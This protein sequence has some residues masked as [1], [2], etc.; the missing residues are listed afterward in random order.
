MKDTLIGALTGAGKS[1]EL[2]VHPDQIEVLILPYGGRVLGLFAAGSSQNFL[3]THPA[4]STVSTARSF[5][6]SDQ[7]HNSGGDRTWLAPE[8]DFFFPEFP[9][10][11]RYWQPRQL[12]PGDYQLTRGDAELMLTNHL[13]ARLSRSKEEVEVRITKVIAPAADPLRHE[14]GISKSG[15][16]Y[17]GYTLRTTL[18][19]T[20]GG[21]G[22]SVV[23]LW[24]LLQLPHGGELLIPTHVRTQPRIYFGTIAPDDLIVGDH[25]VRYRMQATGEQKIGIRAVAATGRLAYRHRTGDGQWVLVIRN[26]FVNPSGAYVDFPWNGP[27]ELG[28]ALQACSIN[29]GLGR[30]S[31]LE[32]HVPAIGPATG[33]LIMEDASQVWAYRGTREQID[34]VT[35]ALVTAEGSTWDEWRSEH[36][37]IV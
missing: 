4:L 34:H 21:S 37:P 18:E 29:S 23:G 27:A 19:W 1:V 3:W 5:F 9:R 15:I 31:E 11:D 14:H 17:A 6:G 25:L 16:E 12:D 36:E 24:N 33:R 30:F 7:W 32:Y 22:R 20:G 8:V 2:C 28:D 35:G 26:V 13:T 10:T